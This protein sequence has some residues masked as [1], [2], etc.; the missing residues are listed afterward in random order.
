MLIFMIGND[1][2]AKVRSMHEFLHE[3]SG[4]F[5]KC[6]QLVPS[7]LTRDTTPDPLG[8]LWREGINQNV[9]WHISGQAF[10]PELYGVD[11]FNE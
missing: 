4:V 6:S 3:I 5:F 8:I 1:M 2:I 7:F 10:E 11:Y 9:N